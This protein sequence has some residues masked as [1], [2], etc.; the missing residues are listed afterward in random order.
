MKEDLAPESVG[1]EDGPSTS[2]GQ[3]ES[4]CRKS[5]NVELN[6]AFLGREGVV[7]KLLPPQ[8]HVADKESLSDPDEF[9][10]GDKECADYSLE[11][12]DIKSMMDDE[13]EKFSRN[14]AA[15][16]EEY[17]RNPPKPEP[18]TEA[19]FT[20]PKAYSIDVDRGILNTRAW[21]LQERLLAP[22]TIHFTRDHIY[23]ED[24]DDLCGEDWVRQYF[25]WLSC[26]NK[27]SEQRRAGLFPEAGLATKNSMTKSKKTAEHNIWFQRSMYS[28]PESQRIVNPWFRICE[29]FS[30]CLLSYPTDRLAALSGLV[31]RSGM[32]KFQ[33]SKVQRNFLGLWEDNL[34]EQLAWVARRGL[35]VTFLHK[36]NL[37]SWAWI[38]YD[39]PITFL[40]QTPH[41]SSNFRCSVLPRHPP[42]TEL[43]LLEA[44]VPDM[45]IQLPLER[46][47]SLTLKCRLRNIH[48]TSGK[49]TTDKTHQKTRDQLASLLPFH[50][51]PRTGTLPDLLLKCTDCHEIFDQARKLIGF[52][53]FDEDVQVAKEIFCLHVSTL[54]DE[55]FSDAMRE[56]EKPGVQSVDFNAYREPILAYALAVV[57]IKTCPNGTSEYRRIGLAEVNHGWIT[58]GQTEVVRLV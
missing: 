25:T 9:K 23:C 56:L 8:Q 29:K 18:P 2:N 36:L 4:N 54:F 52:I 30:K 22:R 58:K 57:K 45:M 48:A 21:V 49:P 12:S 1:A 40:D 42:S 33:E 24:Q 50:L 39:G 10:T 43:E 11:S 51:D 27:T 46:L 26:V 53:S 19:Y 38:S 47:A 37:P 55:A 31:K 28:K 20:A 17:R 6:I 3:P 35:K 44:D 7:R 5:A 34:H 15:S 41:F 14:L 13:F 32:L 16:D